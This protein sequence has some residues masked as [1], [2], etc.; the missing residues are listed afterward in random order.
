M[1]A[2][3]SRKKRGP[4]LG[5]SS[6]T[7]GQLNSP[8]EAPAQQLSASPVA[9]V[10]P[11]LPPPCYPYKGVLLSLQC[12]APYLQTLNCYSL[13]IANKPFFFFFFL[14]ELL[15]LSLLPLW[16]RRWR[17]CLQCRSPGLIPGWWSSP[18]EGNGDSLQ[19]SCLEN[20]MDRGP[21]W[22]MVHG[23]GL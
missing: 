12:G 7:E 20:S 15:L 11:A 2:E 22:T 17:I 19:Y 21:W 14:E 4:F 16:L 8:W 10:Y 1:T 13:L 5:K 6:A 3:P 9:S 23:V 18:G